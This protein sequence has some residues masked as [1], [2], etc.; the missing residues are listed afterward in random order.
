MCLKL[1]GCCL[2]E[3]RDTLDTVEKIVRLID[4]TRE[5]FRPA[6]PKLMDPMTELVFLVGHV[7]LDILKAVGLI[8]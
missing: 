1:L 3:F 7:V 2:A 4:L 6:M 8:C 5:V